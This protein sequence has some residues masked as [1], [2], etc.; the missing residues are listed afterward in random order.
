MT[1]KGLTLAA[2]L[3]LSSCNAP[4]LTRAPVPGATDPAITSANARQIVCRMGYTST[5]R[6]TRE[7]SHGVKVRLLAEQ[8]LPGQIKDYEL[9]HLIP[10]N[11]GGA[12]RDPAN[13]WL[14]RWDEARAKDDDELEL[15]HAV[16]S[17]RMTLEQAQRRM[18]DK[19]GPKP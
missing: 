14:Q 3:A 10:L 7:W 8:H 1:S 9:D 16:C 2:L 5:I 4:E 13:L 17:G 15:Y 11:I 18:L 6:P 12:P 19:W